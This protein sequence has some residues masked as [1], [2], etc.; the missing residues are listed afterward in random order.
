M[1]TDGYGDVWMGTE[2]YGEKIKKRGRF[3]PPFLLPAIRKLISDG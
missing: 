2:K 1:G 3:Q